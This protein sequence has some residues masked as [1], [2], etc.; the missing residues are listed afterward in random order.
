MVSGGLAVMKQ[1]FRGQL[2]NTALVSRLFQTAKK[3]GI[4]GNQAIYGQGL[5]DVGAAT[6]PWGTPAFMGTRSSLASSNGASIETSFV[7]LGSPLG[8]SLPQTLDQQE[9]AVF[10][11]LGAPFWF[12]ASDFTV[13]SEGASVA[14]RLNRF[15]A[16]PQQPSIPTA[17]QFDVQEEATATETGHLA[18]TH[19]ASRFTMAGPQ[20][21]AAT[22]FQHPQDLEGLTLS[23]TPTSLPALTMTAGYLDENQ[24]LLGSE[25]SGA[26]GSLSGE[27]LLPQCRARHQ[28]RGLAVGSG[29]RNRPSES[30][31]LPKPAHRYHLSPFHQRF[32]SSSH[33]LLSQWQ[34]LA[35][36]SLPALAGPQRRRPFPYPQAAPRKA[37]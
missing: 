7:S 10:D 9:V 13:L 14:T 28:L 19:G 33:P 12:E 16:P 25:G 37:Q 29:R 11:E 18:L 35:L 27:T 22:V 32:P 21:V 3:S 5:M 1:L 2:S 26:F 23:W 15:L 20:G 4:H 6:N 24:S 17:W 36:L 30:C 31:C 34:R 8:D